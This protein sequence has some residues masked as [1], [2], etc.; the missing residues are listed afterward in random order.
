MSAVVDA[1][2]QAPVG[3]RRL[4]PVRS[5]RRLLLRRLVRNRM[6]LVGGLIV[7]GVTVGALL[8]PALAPHSATVPRPSIRLAPPI[9]IGGTGEY[10]LGTDQLGRDILSRLLFGARVSLSLGGLAVVLSGTVGVLAGLVAGYYGGLVDDA[11]MRLADVQLAF[12]TILLAIAVIALVGV[13]VVPLLAVMSLSGWVAYARLTR[14]TVLMI[15]RLDY[16][17]AAR[18]IGQRDGAVLLRHVLPNCVAPV[19]VVATLQIGQMIILESALS[20]F[21]LGTQPP[22]PSWGLMIADGR[23]Y[24]GNAW[25]VSTMPGLAITGTILGANLL[26]DGLRDLL[27]PRFRREV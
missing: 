26:G 24:L 14:S 23:D 22:T 21:G 27:D 10:P 25:W 9:W 17:L 1:V 6:I 5:A 2:A 12:P 13:G 20:F 11:L 18:T 8:A 7:L 16:I 15:K 19:L 4:D 3:R